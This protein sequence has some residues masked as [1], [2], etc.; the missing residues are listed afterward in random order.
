MYLNHPLGVFGVPM[1]ASTVVIVILY[2]SPVRSQ[3]E[4][5]MNLFVY[6]T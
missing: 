3:S 6:I 5:L 4:V 1:E 2:G